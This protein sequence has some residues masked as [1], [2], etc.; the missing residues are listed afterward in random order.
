MHGNLLTERNL[1]R[2]KVEIGMY[3]NIRDLLKFQEVFVKHLEDTQNFS[4][5]HRSFSFFAQNGIKL[6]CLLILRCLISKR[7][8]RCLA[9]TLAGYSRTPALG[10]LA[11]TGLM[12]LMDCLSWVAL[13]GI[14]SD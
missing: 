2:G 12:T 1:G 11:G 7:A 10:S 14:I 4:T 5:G 6:I 13:L 8:S 9:N 3:N